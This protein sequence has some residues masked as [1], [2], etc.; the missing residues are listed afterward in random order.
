MNS[1]L[2]LIDAVS[3]AVQ[4]TAM[5]IAMGLPVRRIITTGRFLTPFLL[6]WLSLILWAFLFCLIIP[7]LIFTAF[8]EKH[9]F[10]YFPDMRGIV[11]AVMIG[12]LPSLVLCSVA[13]LIRVFWIQYH[14]RSN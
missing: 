8:H 1:A 10:E 11:A 6:M 9:V 14:S 13:F 4:L 7:L 12:W 5:I 2:K 3:L